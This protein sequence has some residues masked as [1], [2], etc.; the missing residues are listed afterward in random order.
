MPDPI[1]NNTLTDLPRTVQHPEQT[2]SQSGQNIRSRSITGNPGD[3]SSTLAE[4]KFKDCL[5][6][7]NLLLFE[8]NREVA[9][10]VLKDIQKNPAPENDPDRIRWQYAVIATI[11][12]GLESTGTCQRDRAIELSTHIYTA[13]EKQ[14]QNCCFLGT[15][16]AYC[17]NRI[18]SAI[19]AM[20]PDDTVPI[21]S[22]LR[23]TLRDLPYYVLLVAHDYGKRMD[24]LPFLKSS[25][26]REIA[27]A[28]DRA[29]NDAFYFHRYC[30]K[31]G[32]PPVEDPTLVTSH[33]PY[34]P[35][36]PHDFSRSYVQ[37]ER[38]GT[39]PLFIN[40]NWY[41]QGNE[42]RKLALRTG[43]DY[44]ED[45]K[46]LGTE[47]LDD[48]K[49]IK[50]KSLFDNDDDLS[51][52]ST[53]AIALSEIKDRDP[54]QLLSFYIIFDLLFEGIRSSD[55]T[56][57]ANYYKY[58]DIVVELF[59]DWEWAEFA[60][61]ILANYFSCRI[62]QLVSIDIEKKFEEQRRDL[63]NRVNSLSDCELWFME[64]FARDRL[65]QIRLEQDQLNTLN[66]S[67]N[68]NNHDIYKIIKGRIHD[69]IFARKDPY[70]SA[71][72]FSQLRGLI[73]EA[74][75]SLKED[76][77]YPSGKLILRSEIGTLEVS[78]RR[79]MWRGLPNQGMQQRLPVKR[80]W[81]QYID[82]HTDNNRDTSK[83]PSTH[84]LLSNI[85]NFD[86]N[87]ALRTNQTNQTTSL[88][89]IN[90]N[91]KT[92]LTDVGKTIK[93]YDNNR[94]YDNNRMPLTANV[95]NVNDKSSTDRHNNTNV[96]VPELSP[97]TTS[98]L[99]GDVISNNTQKTYSD[100]NKNLNTINLDQPN[101]QEQP[102]QGDRLRPQT[103]PDVQ[104]GPKRQKTSHETE[105]GNNTLP[106]PTF[107]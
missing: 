80:P 107:R 83:I 84:E 2:T 63:V 102:G 81:N 45:V 37:H 53:F 16:R 61:P 27:G 60:A 52:L 23:L 35:L 90:N 58:L 95:S 88:Q 72:D 100:L 87:Y 54:R 65:T 106:K 49:R 98:H 66:N 15:L 105:S 101:Q 28:Y 74:L 92:I 76:P 77:L 34:L 20:P 39:L 73:H 59:K 62:D 43:L 71:I 79:P 42:T 89:G 86:N 21:T 44:S 1:K 13:L 9:L 30:T 25:N 51:P 3:D 103:S 94:S 29:L 82:D 104:P 4:K 68:N 24:V 75:K 69:R 31:R 38:K 18:I 8:S 91:N 99:H 56:E 70:G 12:D 57:S 5:S 97:I 26:P 19:D 22:Q 32:A 96:L 10:T 6:K 11:L 48:L 67:Q 17:T 33:S 40:F 55:K 41:K 47:R 50:K 7:A 36:A 46:D 85:Y 93:I 64:M 78:L 14:R